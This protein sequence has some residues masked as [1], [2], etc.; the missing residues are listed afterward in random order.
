MR[1]EAA[2]RTASRLRLVAAAARLVRQ[3]AGVDAPS[4]DRHHSVIDQRQPVAAAEMRMEL[5]SAPALVWAPESRVQSSPRRA[6]SERELPARAQRAEQ[7]RPS[8][9]LS[10]FR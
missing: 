5:E 7:R 6:R 9:P 1:Q 3:D 10:L 8:Q 2:E 4:F